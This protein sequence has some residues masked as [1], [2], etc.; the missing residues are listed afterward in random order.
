MMRQLSENGLLQRSI[1]EPRFA[2]HAKTIVSL[3]FVPIDNV[4]DDFDAL[5]NKLANELTPIP[6]W[7]EDNDIGRPGRNNRRSRPALFPPEFRA[8]TRAQ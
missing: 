6:N 3:V 1:A 7:L 4:D 2:L 8:C 5:S